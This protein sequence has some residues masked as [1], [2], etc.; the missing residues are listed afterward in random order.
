MISSKEKNKKGRQRII[1]HIDMDYFFAQI[2]ERE[3]PHFKGKPLIVGADPREGRGRGV[4]SACNY[5]ARKYGIKSGMAI[6]R[7][8]KLCPHGVFLPVNMQLYKKVSESIFSIVREFSSEI[9]S[10]ALDEAYADLTRRVKNFKEA[11]QLAEKIKRK[12]REKERLT[13]SV[14]ISVNKMMAKIACE[15]AKPDGIRVITSSQIFPVIDDMGVEAVPG[16]GPKTK[17]V[18]AEKLKKK[19]PR[20]KDGKLFS[21]KKL[22]ELFGKRGEEFYEKF[23]GRDKSPVVTERKA[24]SVGKEYTFQEDTKKAET[25][26]KVFKKLVSEVYKETKKRKIKGVTVICR[27]EDFETHTKQTT[28]EPQTYSKDFLLKKGMNLLLKFLAGS[29]KKIRLVGFRVMIK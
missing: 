15:L 17:E 27:Y 9:E 18:L 20:I 5:E 25:I 23:R 19:N 4:V 11:K 6:S 12:I 28:F 29:N 7:S 14:G 1:L 24:K 10:V 3:N 26:I 22:V 13:C 21:K 16:I 8:Y 2:E